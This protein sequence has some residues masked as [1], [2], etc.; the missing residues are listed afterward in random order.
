M[1]CLA[2]LEISKNMVQSMGFPVIYKCKASKLRHVCYNTTNTN[3]HFHTS[4]LSFL[5]AFSLVHSKLFCSLIGQ[6]CLASMTV[7]HGSLNQPIRW[8]L[9]CFFPMR[10]Q[11]RK[12]TDEQVNMLVSND[13]Y[14]FLYQN[15]YTSAYSNEIG[16]LS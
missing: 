5:T 1:V 14:K 10:M 8:M 7:W 9:S 12:K 6:I 4:A 13:F 16:S 11:K 3:Y 15:S 2:K